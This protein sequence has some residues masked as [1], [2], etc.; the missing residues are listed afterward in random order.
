MKFRFVS[1]RRCLDFA[2]TL[3][4]RAFS[5]RGTVDQPAT[6]VGLG[7]SGRAGGCGDRDH[8]R[9][10]A[11]P[12]SRCAKPPTG[13]FPHDSMGA[14]PEVA[15]VDLLNE[16]ASQ[17][18]LTPRF[19]PG[20][21]CK[22]RRA[23]RRSCSR[24]WPPICSTCLPDP[25]S[26]RSSEC[27]RPGLHAPLHRLVAGLRTGIGAGCA[28]AATAPRCRPSAPASAAPSGGALP[29]S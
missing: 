11:R 28:H 5:A 26:R 25:T 2:G 8:R 14:R 21:I 17:P 10:T 12:R 23:P 16:R 9:R 18:Q 7:S 4:Y 15:D 27:S 6:V 3:K 29:A 20:R 22:P 1:G 19:A 13:S 24:G